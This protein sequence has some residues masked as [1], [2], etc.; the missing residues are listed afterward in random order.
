MTAFTILFLVILGTT[1]Y[2]G[3][4]YIEERLQAHG[5]ALNKHMTSLTKDK[6]ELVD[7]VNRISVEVANLKTQRAM[8]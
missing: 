4:K 7:K 3:Y 1:G 6:Q 2:I 8:K 5:E